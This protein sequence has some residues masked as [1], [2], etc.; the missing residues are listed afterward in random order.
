MP[1][2][3][4]LEPDWVGNGLAGKTRGWNVRFQPESLQIE[5]GQEQAQ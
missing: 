2:A 4:A 3:A 5:L 1:L